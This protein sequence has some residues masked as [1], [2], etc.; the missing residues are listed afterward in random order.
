MK[1]VYSVSLDLSPYLEF[2]LSETRSLIYLGAV[3]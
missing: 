3:P 2:G 1:V